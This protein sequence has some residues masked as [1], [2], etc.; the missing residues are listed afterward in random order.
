LAN[1]FAVASPMPLF[2][3]VMTATLPSN[4]LLIAKIPP[5]RIS[6]INGRTRFIAIG[7]VKGIAIDNKMGHS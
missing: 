6:R 2:P 1:S 4:R 7:Q 5:Y 3:P